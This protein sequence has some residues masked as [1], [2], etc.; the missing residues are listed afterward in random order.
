M[1]DDPWANLPKVIDRWPDPVNVEW[2]LDKTLKKQGS[3]LVDGEG[4]LYFDCNN[5]GKL[6]DPHTTSFKKLHDDA[7]K[8][9]W[10]V[11]WNMDGLGYKI[12]CG[13][14]VDYH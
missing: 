6:F 5:C 4:Y 11:K 7:N 14:C 9:G 1:K 12:Y 8:L 3:N 2:N 13:E 10:K